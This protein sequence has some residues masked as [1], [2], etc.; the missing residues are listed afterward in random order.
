MFILTSFNKKLI[1]SLL[2]MVLIFN[3]SMPTMVYALTSGPTAPE[4]TSF[5]PIDTTDVVNLIS[6]DFTYNLPLLEIPGPEGGYPISLSYHAGIQPQEEA[7]W[8]GL[9]W[10]LNPGA[11]TRNVNGY[12]DDHKQVNNVVRDYWNGGSTSTYQ[13]G[14]TVGIANM[15]SIGG[16]LSF[17]QDT[18]RGFGTGGFISG[19]IGIYKS[20]DLNASI[21]AS[22]GISPYGQPFASMGG[23]LRIKL[24]ES[25]TAG[26]SFSAFTN[27]NTI[28]YGAGVGI[29]MQSE[30]TSNLP[31]MS[32]NL[33]GASISS[34]GSVSISVAGATTS[35]HNNNY[36]RIQTESNGSNVEIPVTP[37]VNISL[38]ANYL[39]YWSEETANI[40]TNGIL[41]NPN[42]NPTLSNLDENSYDAYLLLEKG[43]NSLIHN[44]PAWLTGGGL[45]N[46]DNYYVSAQGLSGNMRPHA[47]QTSIFMQSRLSGSTHIIKND[48]IIGYSGKNMEFKFENDFSNKYVQTDGSISASNY[49]ASVNF[50][51]PSTS[52]Y[53]SV[54][55]NRLEG[56]RH[57]EYY[58]NQE[59]VDDIAAS[60]GFMDATAPGFSRSTTGYKKDLIGGFMITNSSGVTYHYALPVY[61]QSGSRITKNIDETSGNA[62]YSTAEFA[63]T[64]FLTAITGPDFI[65]HNNNGFPDEQDWGYWVRFDYGKW[66]EKYKWRNPGEGYMKDLDYKFKNYSFG[67]KEVYYLNRIVTRSH[68]AVFEKEIRADAKGVARED[69]YLPYDASVQYTSKTNYPT[70]SLKLKKIY[71]LNN[72]DLNDIEINNS[73]EQKSNLY[74]HN[75]PSQYITEPYDFET[76]HLG[77]NVFD[78]A[79]ANSIRATIEAKSIRIIDFNTDY[80]LCSGLPNSFDE[81]GNIY[82]NMLPGALPTASLYN[83]KKGKLTLNSI[84]FRGK[85]GQSILPSTEFSY[86]LPNSERT[87]Y[88]ANFN[89]IDG[90]KRSTFSMVYN[91]FEPGDLL[92]ITHSSKRYTSV[93]LSKTFNSSTAKYDYSIQWVGELP[94]GLVSGYVKRTKNPNYDKEAYDIWNMFKPDY[95]Q[96]KDMDMARTTSSVSS[97]SKDAWSLREIYT[98]IGTK[99]KMEYESDEYK[100][101]VLNKKNNLV[102]NAIEKSVSGYNENCFKL[103]LE[104]GEIPLN[105]IFTVNSQV[106]F[107]MASMKKKTM[108]CSNPNN[109]LHNAYSN[110]P[111]IHDNFNGEQSYI[112]GIGSNFIV[113][114]NNNLKDFMEY[115]SAPYSCVGAY[116]SVCFCVD[117]NIIL[118]GNVFYD[119]QNVL[120]GGDIRVKSVT[121]EDNISNFSKITSYEYKEP[122]GTPSGVTSFEPTGLSLIDLQLVDFNIDPYLYSQLPILE[123]NYKTEFLT[124]FSELMTT[125]SEVP[126]PGVMYG[127]V[128]VKEKTRN[129]TEEK[130]SPGYTRYEFQVFEEQ[131]VNLNKDFEASYPQS[132]W[133][134]YYKKWSLTDITSAIGSLKSMITYDKDGKE[135]SAILNNY[136][137]DYI[138][139]LLPSSNNVFTEMYRNE[140]EDLYNSQGVIDEYYID[141]RQNLLSGVNYDLKVSMLRKSELPSILI[142]SKSIDYRLNNTSETFYDGY[143]MLTGELIKS[144][145]KDTYGNEYLTEMK[146]AFLVPEYSAMGPKI[147][148][149]E[150]K[151]MLKQQ[152]GLVT[153]K[154]NDQ[155]EPEFVVS[156]S[157]QT[158]SNEIPVLGSVPYSTVW[159]QKATYKWMPPGESTNGLVSV[160][161]SEF[162][163]NYSNPLLYPWYK[164]L[165]EVQLYDRYSHPLQVVDM[166]NTNVATRMGYEQSR[167]IASATLANYYEFA[168]SGAEDQESLNIGGVSNGIPGSIS[169]PSNSIVSFAPSSSQSYDENSTAHTG[170]KSIKLTSSGEAFSYSVPINKLK[171]DRDYKASVWVRND[172]GTVPNA[173]L[174]W[175]VDGGSLNYINANNIN[176]KAGKWYRIDLKI[177]S[178]VISGGAILKVGSQNLSTSTITYFD[179]F[180]FYPINSSMSSYVYDKHTGELTDVLDVNNMFTHYQYDASGNLKKTYK[181]TLSN[182]VYLVSENKYSYA[183]VFNPMHLDG[184]SVTLSN[185]ATKKAKVVITG[186]P[187]EGAPYHVSIY[188]SMN[189]SATFTNIEKFSGF[190]TSVSR[191]VMLSSFAEFRIDPSNTTVEPEFKITYVNSGSYWVKL[192]IEDD[193]GNYREIVKQVTVTN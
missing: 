5:E 65:D 99:I 151:H 169:I 158:W 1:A 154:L 92:E 77:Q 141:S 26:V 117:V 67:T 95:K 82:Q 35:I 88:I 164:K 138:K 104:N 125:A 122:N 189:G 11:I 114:E 13:V 177:P 94:T 63:Y 133:T 134:H 131:M 48:P 91:T 136:M 30:N 193:F 68:T 116:S 156:A 165:S 124:N 52:A 106:N 18:Y 121:T 66:T 40:K 28:S 51:T 171:L 132:A 72:E 44:D 109:N 8:V 167:P 86:E 80:S 90:H 55:T 54:S 101:A 58:T 21:G 192:I 74:N 180:R 61:S 76:F 146:P 126:S 174:Y 173:G 24:D 98:G 73:I 71:L 19:A 12:A 56:G 118:G 190:N 62:L 37:L 188:P 14:V 148:N 4:A 186:L 41:Y 50:G 183:K 31:S 168:Y 87:L 93:V 184:V 137:Y 3:L 10:T 120:Y 147:F 75:I 130:E 42:S 115:V 161:S 23:G 182:N 27:F 96:I 33:L 157:A 113:I 85:G 144:R 191:E 105:S 39:R 178:S 32:F 119:N 111:I 69:S 150:N 145:N 38:G 45:P 172:A 139:S 123:R 160:N 163:F 15:A 155:H 112:R 43:T 20:S 107:L 159:R 7:S 129:G 81:A 97:K 179:D 170:T 143:E 187:E 89:S 152:A 22:I 176:Q 102:I 36:G 103:V 142:S 2:L 127:F 46:Y 9:G 25:T 78:Y 57:I 162:A 181:E 79:D 34:G 166:N 140:S 29:S 185:L 128:T 17:S 149:M 70:S 64:W 16:G 59:I 175:Q 108:T 110:N 6:G 135:L 60:D 83:E 53:Y 49:P 100:K 84:S 47:L 153:T